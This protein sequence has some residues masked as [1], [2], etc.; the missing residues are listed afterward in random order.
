[1]NPNKQEI[2]I[3]NALQLRT[4]HQMK[5]ESMSAGEIAST[6]NKSTT[7]VR[8]HLR[9]LKEQGLVNRGIRKD[10]S[11]SQFTVSAKSAEN[12]DPSKSGG[13]ELVV[14]SLS[15]LALVKW[16]VTLHL[17]ERALQT[18]LE[19]VKEMER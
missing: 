14:F 19:D 5:P 16:V 3:L 13:K 18:H 6:I 15:K 17:R 12:H 1:M 7:Y 8:K 9:R 10:G 11:K 4:L 2:E